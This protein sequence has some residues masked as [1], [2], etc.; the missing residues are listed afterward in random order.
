LKEYIEITHTNVRRIEEIVGQDN[1]LETFNKKSRRTDR[2]M[3][4]G[5]WK[6]APV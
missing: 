3:S 6:I 1:S 5:F 2:G 4:T